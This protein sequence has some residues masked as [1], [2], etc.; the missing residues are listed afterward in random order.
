LRHG[1]YFSHPWQSRRVHRHYSLLAC[2]GIGAKFLDT[3]TNRQLTGSLWAL[4]VPRSYCVS[5]VSSLETSTCWFS[6]Y[7]L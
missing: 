6:T 1:P 2:K 4:C 5:R 7:A 3:E